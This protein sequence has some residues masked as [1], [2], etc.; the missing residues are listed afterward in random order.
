MVQI[1]RLITVLCVPQTNLCVEFV[2][3][4]FSLDLVVCFV[5]S[6]V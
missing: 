1:L 4:C 3:I 5:E 2:P 6:I